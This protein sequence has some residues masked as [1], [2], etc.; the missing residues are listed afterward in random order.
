M[1]SRHEAARQPLELRGRAVRCVGDA[2]GAEAVG[3]RGLLA[4][5]KRLGNDLPRL[6]PRRHGHPALG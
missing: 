5:L 4:G 3:V 6:A 2:P 1:P